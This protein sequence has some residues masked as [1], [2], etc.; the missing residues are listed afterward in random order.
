MPK[1]NFYW[2][3]HYLMIYTNILLKINQYVIK[4]ATKKI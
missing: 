1:V 2:N 3:E 4:I